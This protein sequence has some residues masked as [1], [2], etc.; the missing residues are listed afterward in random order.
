MHTGLQSWATQVV[1][2]ARGMTVAFFAGSL[3]AG[4][5]ASSAIAGAMA[6]AGQWSVIFGS[7]ALL[8]VVLTIVAVAGLSRY[9]SRP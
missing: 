5:A 4:S 7:G 1:P 2:E 6:E 8:V 3:F 9:L